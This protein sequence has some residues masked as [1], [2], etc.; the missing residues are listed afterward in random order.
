MPAR[1]MSF[2]TETLLL[3]GPN[4]QIIFVLLIFTPVNFKIRE[5]IISEVLIKQQEIME[6]ESKTNRGL[7]MVIHKY[8]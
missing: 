3:E 8:N 2:N 7:L 1:T 4:V 5:T 6:D